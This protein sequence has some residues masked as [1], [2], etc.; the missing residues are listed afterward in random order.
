MKGRTRGTILWVR[1]MGLDRAST[2]DSW[3][4]ACRAGLRSL[5]ASTLSRALGHYTTTEGRKPLE[6]ARERGSWRPSPLLRG[7][8]GP[9][10]TWEAS[11]LACMH[12]ISFYMASSLFINVKNMTVS[13]QKASVTWLCAW[14]TCYQCYVKRAFYYFSSKK[15]WSKEPLMNDRKVQKRGSRELGSGCLRMGEAFWGQGRA[16]WRARQMWEGRGF[17]F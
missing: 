12:N 15:L 1:F 8:D 2:M 6:Q 9:S 3:V 5:A 7:R 11:G 16:P 17:S 14:C 4:G 10:C 13:W